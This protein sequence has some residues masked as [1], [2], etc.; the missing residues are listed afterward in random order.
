MTLAD[1][2][3]C[4]FIGTDSFCRPFGLLPDR[5]IA[6]ELKVIRKKWLLQCAEM[7]P[8][9]ACGSFFFKTKDKANIAAAATPSTQKVSM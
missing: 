1:H 9:P 7:L 6:V 3:T 8:R 4:R 5:R 2:L